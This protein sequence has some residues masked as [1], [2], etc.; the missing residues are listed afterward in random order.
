MKKFFLL[1][2]SI[3]LIKFNKFITLFMQTPNVKNTEETILKI[4]SS[5]SSVS[6]YGDGEFLI[7]S[8]KGIYFQEYSKLLQRRLNE[9]IKSKGKKHIVCIPDVFEST[10]RFTDAAEE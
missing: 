1:I 2:Y 9:V 4:T 5:N 7:M 10:E 8:G 6:R 3:I